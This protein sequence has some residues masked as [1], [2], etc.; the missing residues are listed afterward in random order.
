MNG[1]ELAALTLSD[2]GV[3]V[4]F[5]NPGT[6]E[7][8][9]V[10]ALER[11]GPRPILVTHELVAMGA[12]DAHG[13]LGRLGAALVHL[14]PGL[15]NGLAFVHDA[16]R[17]H[18]PML[19][20]VGEHPRSHRALDTP[21]TMRIASLAEAIDVPMIAIDD[22]ALIAPQL[23]AAATIATTQRT[24]V[25]VTLDAV[26]MEREATPSDPSAPPTTAHEAPSIPRAR[27]EAAIDLVRAGE[28]TLLLGAR[29]LEPDARA[30]ARAIA[31]D[32]GLRLLAETFPASHR[33][34]EGAGRIE[35]LAY[36][37][38]MARPQLAT[39]RSVLV[40]GTDAPSA[41]FAHLEQDP[42]LWPLAAPLVRLDGQDE[43][44][45]VVLEHLAKALGVTP[46][47]PPTSQPIPAPD[48]HAA[49]DGSTLAAVIARAVQADD[50]VI[51]EARTAAPALYEQLADA[52][53]HHYIGHP[54]GAI[55][56]GASLALGAATLGASVLAVV[57]DGG[58]LYAP[59]AIWT[60][61]REHLDVTVVLAVNGGYRIL[62]IEQT[63]AGLDLHPELTRLDDPGWDFAGL[64]A[65]MGARTTTAT[66]VAEL[67]AA[68][69]DRHGVHV[70]VAT[71]S[72]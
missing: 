39:A 1:A 31:D 7:L 11:R 21:L 19:V 50:V 61:V 23:R 49:L 8:V 43:D 32:T 18:T 57:A 5:A 24:P 52:R 35:R 29:V 59:Q 38:L 54:G 22:P 12:A 71:V 20:L 47:P 51:D 14:G 37:P 2:L 65:A 6:S 63:I 72:Q 26:A 56:E 36:L 53:R 28:C 40:L 10:D 48:P 64:A 69:R 55:G 13:R 70:I 34:G 3:G 45:R 30:L 58:F 25:V 33:Y 17:A 62:E 27:L 41:W 67:E 68:L 4:V 15:S 66:T 46:A 16:R 60:M 9:L 44:P 42:R